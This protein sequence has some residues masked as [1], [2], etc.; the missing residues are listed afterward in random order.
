M[1]AQSGLSKKEWTLSLMMEFP[2][3]LMDDHAGEENLHVFL[4]KFIFVLLCIYLF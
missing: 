1:H 2:Q 3:K 4:V